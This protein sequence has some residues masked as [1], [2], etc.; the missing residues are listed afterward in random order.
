[1]PTFRQGDVVRV[2]FPYTDHETRQHR[3]ALVVSQGGLGDGKSL[4]W[5]VM[6]TSA[7]NR[8]WPGDVSLATS[9]LS[10]GLPVPSVVRSAKIATIE[11]RH[12]GRI[13]RLTP[14]LWA[15]VRSALRRHLGF[16]EDGG[17]GRHDAAGQSG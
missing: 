4:L 17:S 15:E 10:A 3:P 12:A 8:P 9:Y 7:A 11:T 14:S 2:P 16:E 6:I 1:M 5:V 13:G